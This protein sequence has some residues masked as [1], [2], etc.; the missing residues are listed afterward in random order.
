MRH[1]PDLDSASDQLKQISLATWPI[2]STGQLV[3]RHQYGISA[4]VSTTSFRGETSGG[5]ISSGYGDDNCDGDVTGGYD[6]NGGDYDGEAFYL[7]R[8]YPNHAVSRR[9]SQRR[10]GDG[11][12]NGGTGDD[13][14]SCDKSPRLGGRGKLTQVPLPGDNEDDNGDD[15]GEIVS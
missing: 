5:V 13:A 2:R 7:R 14:G 3:K 12:D 9:K 10:L 4:L 1:Y 6:Q 11:A 15:G 8:T